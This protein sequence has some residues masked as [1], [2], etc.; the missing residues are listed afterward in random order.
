MEAQ[1]HRT[2][3]E[4]PGPRCPRC[5]RQNPR[6]TLR[7][8]ACRSPLRPLALAVVTLLGVSCLS[9]GAVLILVPRLVLP[10][11]SPG[12]DVTRESIIGAVGFLLI[13]A[14]VW[15]LVALRYGRRWAW[16]ASQA[17]WLASELAALGLGFQRRSVASQLVESTAALKKDD[18]W[19]L[20]ERLQK[21]DRLLRQLEHL[22][23]ATDAMAPL[24]GPLTAAYLIIGQ[25]LPGR[26]QGVITELLALSAIG[27]FT[28]YL[29]RKP[30]R[31][32]CSVRSRPGAVPADPAAGP[33]AP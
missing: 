6:G 10:S 11:S 27:A 2:S 24:R 1:A 7:C 20:V 14:Q 29:W 18:I 32:F 9:A 3:E 28:A 19:G 15:V 26:L 33:R 30:V 17:I 23:V 25:W 21:Q 13:S 4:L 31:W 12:H 16:V 22:E 8:E 5:G